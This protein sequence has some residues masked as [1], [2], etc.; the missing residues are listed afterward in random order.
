M[1]TGGGTL[2]LGNRH[3]AVLTGL[4]RRLHQQVEPQHCGGQRRNDLVV[5]ARPSALCTRLRRS[6]S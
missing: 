2:E 4:L 3:P 1:N 6:R 5:Q